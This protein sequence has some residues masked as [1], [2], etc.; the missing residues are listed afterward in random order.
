MS[1]EVF[2]SGKSTVKK[3]AVLIPFKLL[4]ICNA[5]QK[6]L[7]SKEFSIFS[8]GGYVDG[9]FVVNEEYIIPD[10]EVGGSTVDF[11][12]PAEVDRMRHAG[13]NVVLHSHPFQMPN[14]SCSDDETINSNFDCSILYSLGDFKKATIRLVLPDE[15]LLLLDGSIEGIY[16][17]L[18]GDVDVTMIHE[19]TYTPYE[20]TSQECKREV[21][22]PR[23][24]RTLAGEPAYDNKEANRLLDEE[25]IKAETERLERIE[26]RGCTACGLGSAAACENCYNVQCVDC[27]AE[28][29]RYSREL[30]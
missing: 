17:E 11:T 20:Y 6:K 22:G 4:W 16:P 26:K 28:N 30:Y 2:D 14:F 21:I 29:S 5:I 7:P 27:P 15:S 13:W 12:D 24:Q 1:G 9:R 19:K 3:I 8:S 23:G 25:E 10:Q 18:A